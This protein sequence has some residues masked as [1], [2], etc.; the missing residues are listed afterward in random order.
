MISSQ[1]TDISLLNVGKMNRPVNASKIFVLLMV[2]KR[3]DVDYESFEGGDEK[4]KS[5][6][7][8]VVSQYGDIFQE[9]SGLPPKEELL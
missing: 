4:L 1:K 7:F 6:F 8:D 5:D 2:K 9:P 3:D